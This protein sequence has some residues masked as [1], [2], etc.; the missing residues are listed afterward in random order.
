MS[1]WGVSLFCW[2]IVGRWD[3]STRALRKLYYNETIYKATAKKEKEQGQSPMGE[4]LFAH[5][6]AEPLPTMEKSPKYPTS[7]TSSHLLLIDRRTRSNFCLD[8][9]ALL[10]PLPLALV[11]MSPSSSHARDVTDAVHVSR[12]LMP[13][14]PARLMTWMICTRAT[15][16]LPAKVP[17]LSNVRP[18]HHPYIH[19]NSISVVPILVACAFPPRRL[20]RPSPITRDLF[21]MV[22]T[23]PCKLLMSQFCSSIRP[24]TVSRVGPRHG[25]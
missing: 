12:P 6:D 4:L 18:V 24:T 3:H 5:A 8:R 9:T 1:G 22:S 10:T 11:W 16:Q 2:L 17:C 13:T 19:H 20:V 7:A 21:R 23:L 14:L 15:I 25:K